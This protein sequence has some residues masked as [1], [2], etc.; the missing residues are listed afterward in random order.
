MSVSKHECEYNEMERERERVSWTSF[1]NKIGMK[2]K[3]VEMKK[4]SN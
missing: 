2:K 1:I 4:I 3:N